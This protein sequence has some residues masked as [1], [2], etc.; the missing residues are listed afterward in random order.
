MQRALLLLFSLTAFTFLA[1]QTNQPSVLHSNQVQGRQ[2]QFN[3]SD[4]PPHRTCATM[5]MD[6]LLRTQDPSLGTMQQFEQW[7]Q[8]KIAQDAGSAGIY[9][10]PV[11]VHVIHNGEPTGTGSNISLAQ[12]QSQ[13]DVLNEDFRRLNADTTNTPGPYKPVAADI[14]IEFCAASIDENGQPLTEPGVNRV[15]RNNQ[16]FTSPPFSTNYINGVIKPATFW[17]PNQYLNIWVLN[18][19]GNI[20]G[21]AQFP[22]QSGLSGLPTTGSA[23]TDGVVVGYRYFGRGNFSQLSPPFHLGRTAT[24]EVGHWLGLR[25]IWGDGGCGVDDFCNDTPLSDAPNYGCQTSASSCGSSD[26]VENYMDYS[27]DACFNLF[28]EDQ[29]VRMRM[30]MDNSPRRKQLKNSIVCNPNIPPTADF[31]SDVQTVYAGGQVRFTDLSQGNPT[32]WDWQFQG[33]IPATSTLQNPQVTYPNRGTYAVFMKATNAHGSDSLIKTGYITVLQASD[34]DTLNFPPPGTLTYYTISGEPL[35]GWT[36]SFQDISEAQ[37]FNNY[38]PFDYVT[39]AIFFF[40]LAHKSAGSNATVSFK[41]WDNT[42]PNGVPG[43]VLDSVEVD[44]AAIEPFADN[45]FLLQVVFDQPITIPGNFYLGFSM[46]NFT[47]QDSLGLVSNQ[48]GDSPGG[49]AWEQWSDGSWN[50]LDSTYSVNGSPLRVSHFTS[51]LV[52]QTLPYASFTASD[53]VICLGETVTFEAD[54]VEAGYSYTWVFPGGTPNVAYSDSVVVTYDTAGTHPVY[55]IVDGGCAA[56]DDTLATNLI[57]VNTIPSI[58]SFTTVSASCGGMD[59]SATPIISGGTPPFMYNWDAGTGFQ[60]T[61]T[62]DSLAPGTYTLFIEDSRGCQ[63]YNLADVPTADA[64]EGMVQNVDSVSCFGGSDG[65]ATVSAMHGTPPYTFTWP[66]GFTGPTQSGL[67]AGAYVVTVTDDKNC[68]NIFTVLVSEP[69]SLQAIASATNESCLGNDGMVTVNASGGTPPYT[70]TWNNGGSGNPLTGLNAGTYSATITDSEGCSDT[71]SA[72]VGPADTIQ[73]SFSNVQNA[74]CPDNNGTA[75]V[76]A[77]GGNPGYTYS[78]SGGQTG[79]M[80]TT[81]SSGTHVVTVTDV[82]GCIVV[83]SVTIGFTDDLNAIITPNRNICLGDSSEIEVFGGSSYQWSPA[84]QVGA[85]TST[86]IVSPASTTTYTCIVAEGVCIDTA[87]T[88]VAVSAGPTVTI[89]QGDSIIV[90]ENEQVTLDGTITGGTTPYSVS[91][92]TGSTTFSA[93]QSGPVW[94]VVTDLNGCVSTDTIVVIVEDC[95]GLDQPS[96]AFDV[97]IY[98]NPASTSVFIQLESEVPEDYSITVFNSLGQRVYERK[99]SQ[100]QHHTIPVHGWSAGMYQL[101]IR[102]ERGMVQRRFTVTR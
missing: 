5:T 101:V 86:V 91:W 74:T 34:C 79:N 28:T 95:S 59:G 45:N 1:A 51:P 36:N 2:V 84:P 11:I 49:L 64:P 72:T 24:H 61:A 57:S 3:Q 7:I 66:G 23:S 12:V 19:S 46:N 73:I 50:R 93:S 56:S 62:A 71:T 41:M 25:H 89:D 42:G 78:W 102:G 47:A 85:G 29:K 15:N 37:Y 100:T 88:T 10:I 52:T 8:Q 26:M 99:I 33:G 76:T 55:M 32:Q 35:I 82:S 48:S 81:L 39:G 54:S 18:I 97:S 20:L 58:D 65:T 17:D 92:S 77:T 27:N 70:Y 75:T 63:D 87:T 90:C 96:S 98:P 13:I 44:L 21:Y 80:P 6:S 30:V 4:V 69:D 43:Q 60:N 22:V 83:D 67:S 9:T 53:T 16:G 40:T 94:V 14:E 38:Q 68:T 31:T